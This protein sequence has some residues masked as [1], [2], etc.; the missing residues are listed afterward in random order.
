MTSEATRIK[1]SPARSWRAP[2][3]LALATSFLLPVLG[4]SPVWAADPKPASKVEAAAAKKATP[5]ATRRAGKAPVA[6]AP[7]VQPPP[8][9]PEQ[10][11]AADQVFYG[12][13]ECEFNQRVDIDPHTAFIAYVAVKSGKKLFV[14]KPVLSSTG[15]IRLEDVSG[16]RLMVQIGSKSMLL[17]VKSGQ[18]ELDDCVHPKQREIMTARRVQAQEEEAAKVAAQA[19]AAAAAAVVPTAATA[20]N[21]D[22][23]ATA[24]N[25]SAAAL[26]AA[27][28]PAAAAA[29]AASAASAPAEIGAGP[30]AAPPAPPASAVSAPALP[31]PAVPAPAVPAPALEPALPPAP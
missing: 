21:T 8:A 5:K 16:E 18:R 7:P 19:A 6:V 4:G 1:P 30:A 24:S 3:R 26:P 2:S 20:P 23:A 13:Y 11:E 12:S 10:I 14:M 31:A 29:T 17:N 9:T 28:P 27:A 25:P 15:A 22:P